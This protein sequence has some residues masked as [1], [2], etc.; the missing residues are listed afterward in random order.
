MARISRKNKF[1]SIV[2][3]KVTIIVQVETYINILTLTYLTFKTQR[4]NLRPIFNSYNILS[5]F[6]SFFRVVLVLD[7]INREVKKRRK[8]RKNKAKGHT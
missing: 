3:Y 5:L 8:E 1:Y 7:K 4:S 2:Q 6:C